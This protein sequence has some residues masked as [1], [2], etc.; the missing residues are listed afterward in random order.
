MDIPVGPVLSAGAR[1]GWQEMAALGNG[2]SDH[3]K[4]T[5]GGGP[6]PASRNSTGLGLWHFVLWPAAA[7]AGIGTFTFGYGEGFSY[8]STNPEACAN[9][10][11]MQPRLD[12]YRKASHHTAATCV[13]CHLPSDFLGKYLA[14]LRNGWNHSVAFTTGRFA[15]PIVIK[16]TNSS[17]LQENCLACHGALIHDLTIAAGL[18]CVHCHRTVGHGELAGLGGPPGKP[19]A[20]GVEGVAGDKERPPWR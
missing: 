1:S 16:E 8:L 6:S 11:I 9:C 3:A 2:H 10:H 15:E 19:A 20:R 7:L 12:S 13:D 18:R 4:G 14:K 17:I 5:L